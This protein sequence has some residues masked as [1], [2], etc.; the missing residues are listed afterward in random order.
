MTDYDD[1]MA[2]A[3][4]DLHDRAISEG[5]DPEIIRRYMNLYQVNFVRLIEE[6]RILVEGQGKQFVLQDA[7]R[8]LN[9]VFLG[10]IFKDCAATD[11][12][13]RGH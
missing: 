12:C 7:V 13:R 6:F 5:H 4:A 3:A 8:F 11:E 2:S 9:S 10:M 1:V